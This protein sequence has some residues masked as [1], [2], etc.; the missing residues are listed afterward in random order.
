MLDH[1]RGCRVHFYSKGYDVGCMG[2]LGHLASDNEL[3]FTNLEADDASGVYGAACQDGTSHCLGW[4]ATWISGAPIHYCRPHSPIPVLRPEFFEKFQIRIL[5]RESLEA[6]MEGP[7]RRALT[8]TSEAEVLWLYDEDLDC[9]GWGGVSA[10][11]YRESLS[12]VRAKVDIHFP[13]RVQQFKSHPASP[14]SDGTF[15]SGLAEIPSHLPLEFV[16]FPRLK[17]VIGMPSY[18]MRFFS[19]RK[20]VRV[21]SIL[22]QV[23]MTENLSGHYQKL[24]QRWIDPEGNIVPIENL[25]SFAWMCSHAS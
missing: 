18:A 13:R 22:P 19:T 7:C 10:D 16:R 17:W 15:F 8:V 9:V 3:I 20:G 12:K 21:A 11:V 25:E 14:R 23:P 6:A 24:L 2:L 5:S 4:L 1:I